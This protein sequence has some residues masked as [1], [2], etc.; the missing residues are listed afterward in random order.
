MRR[1]E[2]NIKIEKR[3]KAGDVMERNMETSHCTKFLELRVFVV[4]RLKK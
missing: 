3:R 2:V 1:A 4:W